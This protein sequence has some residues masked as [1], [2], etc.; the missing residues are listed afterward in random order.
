MVAN[1]QKS[2]AVLKSRSGERAEE[3]A[4]QKLNRMFAKAA[5]IAAR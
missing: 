2:F 3:L 4:L 1:A 5:P